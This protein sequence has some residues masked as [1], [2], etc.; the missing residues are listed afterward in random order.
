[1]NPEIVT[2]RAQTLAEAI[3][4]VRDELGPD[5]AVLATREV[6]SPLGRLLG[7]RSIEVTASSDVEVPSRLPAARHTASR[8][9]Q[10][11]SGA[12]L[13]DFRRR[14][15]DNLR[16]AGRFEDSLVERLAYE[17]KNG[18]QPGASKG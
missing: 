7:V 3:K 9:S 15:R 13:Q 1:M 5:A 10:S 17:G 6:G 18:Q 4:L 12:E 16:L 14:I 8:M 2:F 11:I